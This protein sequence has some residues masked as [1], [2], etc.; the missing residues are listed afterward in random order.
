MGRSRYYITAS[1]G[2]T[3]RVLKIDRT[4]AE[5]LNVVEDATHY[6]A[7]QLDL[8]LRMVEDGNK[9]QGGLNK[10]MDFYGIVGFVRFTNTWHLCLITAR[11]I[12]GLLGGHYSEL[13]ARNVL[14][15]EFTT[16]TRLKCVFPHSRL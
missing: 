6:D 9:S 1:A 13:G 4:D 14:T 10:V 3:H 12:V 2:N 5:E 11:S 15:G 7:E 16:A 8:L